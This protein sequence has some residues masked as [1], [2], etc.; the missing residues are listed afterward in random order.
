VQSSCALKNA[1][2]CEQY[3]GL[4]DQLE[5]SRPRVYKN[6]LDDASEELLSRIKIAPQGNLL[7]LLQASFPFIGIEELKR[8]PLT[9]LE[10]LSPVPAN[11]LK[12]I[13]RDL[14]IFR[15]CSLKVQRQVWVMDKGTLRKHLSS[16][17]DSY[18]QEKCVVRRH[19][20]IEDVQLAPL[21]AEEDWSA[22]RKESE[23][24]LGAAGQS[25]SSNQ[26]TAT[27]KIVNSKKNSKANAIQARKEASKKAMTTMTTG[28][29][30][31]AVVDVVDNKD[32]QPRR[33]LRGK[34]PAIHRLRKVVGDNITLYN[35][36]VREI[37]TRYA[38]TGD[39]STCALRSQFLMAFHDHEVQ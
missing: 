21:V 20:S 3:L 8:I 14:S 23:E 10:R 9:I 6:I 26:A 35:A 24:D 2:G 16:V 36:V 4:L 13:S 29:A 28:A 31:A 25:S 15:Q 17:L 18:G 22:P 7:S 5:I 33:I 1:S 39:P 30:L 11:Y 34:S 37:R 19:S 38:N 32:V 12:L 27:K